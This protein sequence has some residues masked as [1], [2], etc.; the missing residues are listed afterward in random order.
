[1]KFFIF[2]MIDAESKLVSSTQ[3]ET[4]MFIDCVDHHRRRCLRVGE[5]L[6]AIICTCTI[7][8]HWGKESCV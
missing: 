1:M 4:H 8:A 5:Y 6:L 2:V 3:L 7:L